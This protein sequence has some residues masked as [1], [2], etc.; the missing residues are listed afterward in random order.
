MPCISY[1][2]DFTTEQADALPQSVGEAP[3]VTESERDKTSV[4]LSSEWDLKHPGATVNR[5]DPT[6]S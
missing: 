6:S 4:T 5:Q 1:R 2:T 3:C